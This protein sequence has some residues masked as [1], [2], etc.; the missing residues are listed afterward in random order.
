MIPCSQKL[1]LRPSKPTKGDSHPSVCHDIARMGAVILCTICR[2]EPA[3]VGGLCINCDH[4]MDDIR[5][6]QSTGLK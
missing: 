4:L 1:T 6:D 3:E 2:K 5:P